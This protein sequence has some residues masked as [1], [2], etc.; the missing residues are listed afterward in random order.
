MSSATQVEWADESTLAVLGL[1][2]SLVVP[3]VHLVPVSGQTSALPLVDGANTVAAGRGTRALYLA[4][5]EGTL[6]TR[7]GSSWTAVASGVRDPAFP[8]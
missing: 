5:D 8:G 2:G 7:Q 6:L 4:D 3:S 1:S